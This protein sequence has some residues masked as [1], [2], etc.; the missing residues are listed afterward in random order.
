MRITQPEPIQKLPAMQS[1]YLTNRLISFVG[2]RLM[3]FS[4]IIGVPL[5]WYL[6]DKTVAYSMIATCVVGAIMLFI[7]IVREE[8]KR[9][10]NLDI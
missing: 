7:G 1:G 10:K 8:I 4:F 5:V 6:K 2:M 9:F 3:M